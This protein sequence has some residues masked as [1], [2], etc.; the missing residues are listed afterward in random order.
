MITS[1]SSALA[2]AV[3][4]WDRI[5]GK[6]TFM[7]TGTDE[8]GQKV[9]KEAEKR[10]MDVK[11]YCDTVASS[12]QEELSHYSLTIDRFIRTTDDDHVAVRF[13]GRTDI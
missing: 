12:F 8:H 7:T 10:K 6:S 4:R 11:Q 13:A 3:V 2:D 9:Q 1:Y 5:Q